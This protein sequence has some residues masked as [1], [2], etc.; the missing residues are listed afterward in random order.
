LQDQV[1]EL[2]RPFLAG[3]FSLQHMKKQNSWLPVCFNKDAHDQQIWSV[4]QHQIVCVTGN[5][6]GVPSSSPRSRVLSVTTTT[7]AHI[8]DW[9]CIPVLL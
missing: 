5:L 9:L 8:M 7:S 3:Q 1:Q 6:C 4:N 2:P